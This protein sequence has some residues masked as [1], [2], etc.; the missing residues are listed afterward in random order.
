M[1]RPQRQ[2]PG[3]VVMRA[4]A[5]RGAPFTVVAMAVVVVVAGAPRRGLTRAAP[6][7]R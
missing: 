6:R 5:M 3:V 1:K 2:V 4:R 7:M